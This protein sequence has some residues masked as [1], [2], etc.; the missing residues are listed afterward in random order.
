LYVKKVNT[1]FTRNIHMTR[2]LLFW[3]FKKCWL[4]VSYWRF[5]TAYWSRVK[6]SAWLLLME[7]STHITNWTLAI[8]PVGSHF[9]YWAAQFINAVFQHWL[10]HT[11]LFWPTG[12]TISFSLNRLQQ[13]VMTIYSPQSRLC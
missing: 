6:H 13:N 8:Q 3:D 4:A 10:H 7:V 1:V 11:N 9:T 12:Y 2:P 5:G